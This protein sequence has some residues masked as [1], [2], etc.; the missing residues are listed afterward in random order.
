MKPGYTITHQK[1]NERVCNGNISHLHPQESCVFSAMRCKTGYTP[2]RKH[3]FLQ[4][5]E[6][7]QRGGKS[8]LKSRVTMLKNR[9]SGICEL[10]SIFFIQINSGNLLNDPR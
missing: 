1:Q 6:H 8:A 4:V 2:C 7:F 9:L 3:S 5:F 10:H